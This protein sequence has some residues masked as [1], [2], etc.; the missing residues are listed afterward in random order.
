M[1][2]EKCPAP[3]SSKSSLLTEVKTAYLTLI[4]SIDLAT[5]S[6]SSSS[7][8]PLGFPVSTEQNLQALVQTDPRSMKV[9][10]PLFQHSLI[11]GH[12]ASSQTVLS[13]LPSTWLFTELNLLFS[14]SFNLIQSGFLSTSTLELILGFMPFLIDTTPSLEIFFTGIRLFKMILKF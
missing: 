3:P 6:G 10:V 4:S 14:F 1:V 2:F 13:L 11:L 8:L 9:A 12:I 7:N 5:L